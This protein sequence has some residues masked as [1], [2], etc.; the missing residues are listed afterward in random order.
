MQLDV[1]LNHKIPAPI[2]VNNIS[3]FHMKYCCG[4]RKPE[5]K[6]KAGMLL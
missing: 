5:E 3:E 2:L 1:S 4:V 6:V